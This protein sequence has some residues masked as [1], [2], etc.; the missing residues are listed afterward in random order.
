MYDNCWIKCTILHE[1]GHI[2][3]GICKQKSKEE[4]LAHK[5]G[6]ETADKYNLQ[7]VKREMVDNL[8]EWGEEKWNSTIYPRRYILAYKLAL[9]D[10]KWAKKHGLLV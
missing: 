6:I 9:K 2:V 3:V 8:R 5:W 10:K 4:F 7:H 1:L